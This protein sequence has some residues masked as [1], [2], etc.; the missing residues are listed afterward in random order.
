M[1][2][3][4][5]NSL[6]RQ[7][8]REM[9]FMERPWFMLRF[10]AACALC[11]LVAG[12]GWWNELTRDE[13]EEAELTESEA[14]AQS[15]DAS[16]ASPTPVS[17]PKLAIPS[18]PG[19]RPAEGREPQLFVKTVNEHLRQ[20]TLDGWLDGRT[21]LELTMAITQEEPRPTGSSA[22]WDGPVRYRCEYQ[23]IRMKQEL[24]NQSAL[25]YDS[26]VTPA[27][28]PPS[29]A[30]YHGLK[31]NGFQF[32]LSRDRRLLEVV[33]FEPFLDRCLQPVSAEHREAIR[34]QMAAGSPHEAI[35]FFVDDSIGL[36]PPEGARPGDRWERSRRIAQPVEILAAMQYTLQQMTPDR[37]GVEFTGK[38]TAPGGSDPANLT[39]PVEA[40]LTARDGRL[41]GG[42]QLDRQTGLPISA[43]T[44]QSIDLKVR[45]ADGTEFE[46][47]KTTLATLNARPRQA[48]ASAAE[49]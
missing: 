37:V 14:V 13:S 43:R 42:Y 32:W 25:V 33:G 28:V 31:G 49:R 34:S 9:V 15:P 11:A 10:V 36:I 5:A 39:V 46:Q 12:C 26:A 27:V 8:G 35:A 16:A 38:L 1:F 40:K 44:E 17:L 41:S 7:S 4:K 6:A 3:G 45:L 20:R 22:A 29:A 47:F 21:E 23:R 18:V 2:R 24:P 48:G 30:A 19:T